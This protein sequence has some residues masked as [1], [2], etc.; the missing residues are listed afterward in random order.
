MG[1]R[2]Q[3]GSPYDIGPLPLM[4]V[5]NVGVL[6]PTVAW[7]KVPVGTEAGLGPGDIVL[8]WDPAP[9]KG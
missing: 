5:S 2:F 3:N 7:I 8:D 6:W 1:D 4:S 9:P